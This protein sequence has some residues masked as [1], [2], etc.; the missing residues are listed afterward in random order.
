MYVLTGANGQLGRLVLQHLL[1]LVPAQQIIAT[2]RS[3]E[4]LV[5]FEARGVVVRRA[6]FTDP[7]TLSAAFTGARSL[8]I[9]STNIP[10]NRAEQHRAAVEAAVNAGVSHI[11]YTSCP[12]ASVDASNLVQRE[13]G[14]TEAALAASSVAWTALRNHPYADVLPYLISILQIGDQLLIPEGQG[15]PAWVTREDCARIAAFVLAGKI[16]LSGPVDVTGPERLGL[17]D[18]AQRWSSIS[19]REVTAQVLPESELIA[20]IIAQGI[21]ERSAVSA[22]GIAIGVTRAGTSIISDS[23]EQATGTKALPVDVVLRSLAD[24]NSKQAENT[25]PE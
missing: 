20:Q 2:T 25:A 15:K 8:L 5:D 10:G 9:I 14:L 4:K 23:V 22:A 24:G 21:P 16:A 17:I 7:A 11:A 3:P 12:E 13:H 6:D 19:G 18:I 1:T